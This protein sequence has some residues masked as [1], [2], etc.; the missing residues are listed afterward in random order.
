M[1]DLEEVEK[2]RTQ[3]VPQTLR[4]REVPA[5]FQNKYSDIFVIDVSKKRQ[6]SQLNHFTSVR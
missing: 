2:P 3:I 4:L 1:D 5:S 6:I